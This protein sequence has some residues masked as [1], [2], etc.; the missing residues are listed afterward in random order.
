MNSHQYPTTRCWGTLQ[1]RICLWSR[2]LMLFAVMVVMPPRARSQTSVRPALPFYDYNSISIG[3]PRAGGRW[4]RG[5]IERADIFIRPK[6]VMMEHAMELTFSSKGSPFTQRSDTL[7]VQANFSLP[8]EAIITDSWLWLDDSTVVRAQ[9]MDRWTASTIYENIVRRRR[10]PSLLVKNGQGNY[11]LSIF[12]MPGNMPRKV[13]ITALM[14]VDWS[15]NAA[16][17]VIPTG[18]LRAS[19]Q[20]PAMR[21]NYFPNQAWNNPRIL[22]NAALR[23]SAPV[24][25]RNAA[26]DIQ[27]LVIDSRTISAS[28]ALT[29]A[30]DAPPTTNG[31]YLNVFA[32]S[33]DG[34]YQLAFRPSQA[35]DV[36]APKKVAVLFDYDAGKTTISREELLK[37]TKDMIRN[38]FSARDS[39]N[40]IFSQLA[41]KRHSPTWLPADS[42]TVERVFAALDGMTI[43]AYSNL[44]AL[45]ANGMEFIRS[46]SRAGVPPDGTLLLIANSDQAGTNATANQLLRDLQALFSPLPQCNVA[47]FTS[48]NASWQHINNTSYYGNEYFY[49]N[50]TRLTGGYYANVRSGKTFA[51]MMNE[52]F[53]ALGGVLTLFD[54]HTTLRNGFCFGR[55]TSGNLASHQQSA[56]AGGTVVQVGKFR[57][58]PPFVIQFSG[59][60]RSTPFSRTIEVPQS[61]MASGDVSNK[62][63][64]AGNYVRS[65]ELSPTNN[66]II[67]DIVATSIENRVLSQYTAFLALETSDT[68]RFVGTGDP[69][70]TST[71]AAREASVVL[72]AP[73]MGG[74][75]PAVVSVQAKPAAAAGILFDVSPN[76]L[77]AEATI[78]VTLP[79]G[80]DLSSASFEVYNALG[81]KVKTFANNGLSGNQLR[82]VWRGET[83]SG[84]RL[85]R[86]A[87]LFVVSTPFQRFSVTMMLVE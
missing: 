32:D 33:A 41:I 82:F 11:S 16:T 14:P 74:G 78:T 24:R 63:I 65:M 53:G 26:N 12:P 48:Q 21:L 51:S 79:E 56:L 62:I 76:P 36:S 17:V 19:S 35:L 30:V 13:R 71:P 61:M 20:V 39:F 29:L 66:Q 18:I 85:P 72:P 87:Y 5:T 15:A 25:D 22:E 49:V 47:D 27:T 7:E 23:F 80:F 50:L 68:L 57:G 69:V 86:G 34:Y 58:T 84:E 3:D 55:Y 59:V 31:V 52:V 70:S 2:V 38:Q 4:V 77:S 83:A 81:Q 1:Q 37:T 28:S 40:L 6:G 54:M 8:Q 9:I 64:W 44:P 43:A 45:L 10:D 75:N 67:R 42:A 46:R 60:I 73:G